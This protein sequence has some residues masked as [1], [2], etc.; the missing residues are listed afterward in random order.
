VVV[1]VSI[2]LELFLSILVEV[3]VAVKVEVAVLKLGQCGGGEAPAVWWS[4]R[5]RFR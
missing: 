5:L 3:V 1:V 4:L 2:L